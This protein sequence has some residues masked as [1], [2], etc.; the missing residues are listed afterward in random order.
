MDGFY[1]TGFRD[2]VGIIGVTSLPAAGPPRL[3][4]GW[5]LRPSGQ[6]PE[7]RLPALLYP[8]TL[9]EGYFAGLVA[10]SPGT[11]AMSPVEY[12]GT[13]RGLLVDLK[14]RLAGA[15]PGAPRE[16]LE[17]ASHVL[18]GEAELRDLLNM[19]MNVLLRV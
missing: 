3:P 17:R 11:E 6:P 14:A 2:N 10:V 5:G 19:Y 9:L 16:L 18:E 13:L 8:K 12:Q 7:Q 1:P 4:E 15:D